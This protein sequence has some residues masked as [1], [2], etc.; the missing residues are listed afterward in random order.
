M[1]D[2]SENDA[3]INAYNVWASVHGIVG[4]LRRNRNGLGEKSKCSDM[5]LTKGGD[6]M[7]RRAAPGGR[8][9][10]PWPF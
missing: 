8:V 7:A 2:E 3:M 4:I 9:A 10:F 5:S 6:K 1:P